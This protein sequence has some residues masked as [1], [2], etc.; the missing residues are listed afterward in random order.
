RNRTRY[1]L[2]HREIDS[3]DYGVP[4]RRRRV[5]AIARRD[6]RAFIWPEPTH[7]DRPVRAYDA[8]AGVR[9]HRSPRASGKW[10][11]LLPSIPEGQNYQWH[12]PEGGGVPLFGAR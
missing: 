3:A 8:L 10:A 11:G 5:I 1:R 4:Q 9:V 6:G 12:T 7:A 2:D